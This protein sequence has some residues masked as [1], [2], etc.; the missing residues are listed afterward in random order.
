MYRALALKALQGGT[1]V[2]DPIAMETMTAATSIHLEPGA[3]GN[4]VLLDG[5]DVTAQLR[6]AEVTAA[7]SHVSVHAAVRRWMVQEQRTLGLRSATGVVMEGRD[8]GTVVFPNATVKIFLEA[9]V[10]A[11]GE[12]RFDQQVASAAAV[13][14]QKI[15]DEIAERDRRDRN[16]EASPLHPAADAILIDT[17]AMPLQAVLDHAPRLCVPR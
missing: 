1:A 5:V 11:R 4:Q 2:D 15:T 14:Q 6:T 10:E 12:R 17:T 8:I 9:S 7:A 13:T 16:R 3:L